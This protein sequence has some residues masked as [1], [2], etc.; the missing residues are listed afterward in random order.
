MTDEFND[1]LG[2]QIVQGRWFGREDDGASYL[3][4]VI[5]NEMAEELFGGQDPI[6]QNLAPDQ[7]PGSN[8]RRGRRQDRSSGSS[9]SW[10]WSRPIVKTARS[11]A[12]VAGA[13][14][15]AA[16]RHRSVD[17]REPAPGEP[18]PADAGGHDA[19]AARNRC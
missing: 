1:V 8:P 2:L 3:P 11:T 19:R 17:A 14:S 18:D 13:L 10:A 16:D 4:V 6:G 9:A 7:T 12:G 5:N 15:Q